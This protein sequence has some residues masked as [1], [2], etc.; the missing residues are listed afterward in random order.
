MARTPEHSG[1]THSG[2]AISVQKIKPFGEGP[3]L[4]STTSMN[5][6]GRL[7]AR[8][9]AYNENRSPPLIWTPIRDAAAYALIVE[10]PDAPRDR[11][12]VHWLIWNIPGEATSL[13]ENLPPEAH[14]GRI[15]GAVQ[16]VNDN[17]TVGYFGP[18]PPVGH[19]VHNYHFQIFALAAPLNFAPDTPLDVLVNALKGDT[20]AYGD[21][22]V[23]YEAPN[24]Q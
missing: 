14:L 19:G 24:P 5:L 18:R 9:S 2:A 10:D 11:P 23:T 7:D 13:P 21:L 8:H 22:I 17:G 6:E 12:F 20:M 16:G 4:L 3:M 15:G 1:P